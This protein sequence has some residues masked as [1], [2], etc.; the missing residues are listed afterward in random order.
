MN[1]RVLVVPRARARVRSFGRSVVRSVG[2][3]FAAAAPRRRRRRATGRYLSGPN[4]TVTLQLIFP[5]WLGYL[6]TFIILFN[7]LV[8]ISLYVTVEF[9]NAFQ[10]A[11]ISNDKKMVDPA[12]GI[13]ALCRSTNLC[14]ELGQIE[15]VI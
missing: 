10:A 3:S 1:G 4:A 7:N 6:F 8:P 12:T 14:Q 15:C 13:S 5:N 9:C 2:R 11:L